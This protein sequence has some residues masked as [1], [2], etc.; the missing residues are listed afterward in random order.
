[1]LK[2][3]FEVYLSYISRKESIY[4]YADV[5]IQYGFSMLF[6][7]ALPI[8]MFF[9]LFSNYIKMKFNAWKLMTVSKTLFALLGAFSLVFYH[10]SH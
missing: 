1:M 7:T 2:Q 8:A 3:L 10:L 5:A 6:V 9:S 4:N